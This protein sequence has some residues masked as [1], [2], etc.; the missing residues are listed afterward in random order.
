MVGRA[1]HLVRTFPRQRAVAVVEV[2]GG[3]AVLDPRHPL[4]HE[5]NRLLV[6]GVD[7]EHVVADADDVLGGAG[8]DHRSVRTED[9]LLARSLGTL[10]WTVETLLVMAARPRSDR[11]AGPASVVH[12][13]AVEPLWR[14]GWRRAGLA[15]VDVEALVAREPTNDDVLEVRHV[16]VLVGGAVVATAQLRSDGATAAV[17]A[18][19]THPDHR[20][21]GYADAVL[22]RALELAVADGTNLVVLEAAEQDWPRHW[23]ARRGFAEVGRVWECLRP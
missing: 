23:Y 15:A 9:A 4:S 10:G 13:S 14:D 2:R 17:E 11:R 18:V 19:M 12:R 8:L 22:A 5:H 3:V 16:A 7:A 1:L 21:R 20:G 6:D